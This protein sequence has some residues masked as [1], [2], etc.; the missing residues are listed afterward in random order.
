MRSTLMSVSCAGF[1]LDDVANFDVH[2]GKGLRVG[3]DAR[4]EVLLPRW[5]G[6]GGEPKI[7]ASWDAS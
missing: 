7:A 2:G 4:N 1:Q 3:R 5:Q 6:C